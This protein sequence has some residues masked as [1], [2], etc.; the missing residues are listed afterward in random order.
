MPY[1]ETC[2]PPRTASSRRAALCA[3]EPV[4][5]CSRLPSCSGAAIRRSTAI[6]ECVRARAPAPARGAHALDLLELGE[7]PGER[8]GRV[9]RG[10]QVEV[11][12]AVGL[13]ADRAGEQHVRAGIGAARRAPPPALRRS[14]SRAAAA[15]ARLGEAARRRVSCERLQ[16]ARLELGPEAAHG[17]HPLRRRGLAQRRERVHAELGVQQP[18]AL[19][20]EPGQAGERHQP[21]RELRPQAL[22][23]GDRAGLHQGEIFSCSVLPTPGSSLARPSRARAATDTGRSRTLWRRSRRRPRGGRSRRRARRGRRAP[24]ARR[25]SRRLMGPFATAPGSA[26]REPP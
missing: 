24:R 9:A 25:R 26:R 16:H 1:S 8:A 10:D 12:D 21:R 4:K 2:S 7:A 11:L 22:R 15:P 5:C 18:R 23:R 20:A 19:G 13:P 14:R 6:P 17:A 3:P